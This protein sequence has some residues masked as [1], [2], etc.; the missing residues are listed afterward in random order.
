MEYNFL[1]FKIIVRDGEVAYPYSL[2]ETNSQIMCHISEDSL[3]LLE[4]CRRTASDHYLKKEELRE[5]L[6]KI[7]AT[8][9]TPK[10]HGS[11]TKL[12]WAYCPLPTILELFEV[13]NPYLENTVK[14]VTI[15]DKA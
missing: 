7:E 2:T 3:M 15:R 4:E 13:I 10:L 9:V 14:F 12:N 8:G 5:L 6:A 1:Q 11:I